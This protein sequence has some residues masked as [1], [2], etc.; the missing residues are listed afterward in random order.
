MSEGLTLILPP[1]LNIKLNLAVES[2]SAPPPEVAVLLQMVYSAIEI[3]STTDQGDL[4]PTGRATALLL[5]VLPLVNK[6]YPTLAQGTESGM[7]IN[8]S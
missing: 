3:L 5:G 8:P 2:K 7:E 6:A 4:S 1:E